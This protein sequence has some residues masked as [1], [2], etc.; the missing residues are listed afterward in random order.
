MRVTEELGFDH[1]NLLIF[2]FFVCKNTLD[3]NSFAIVRMKFFCEPDTHACSTWGMSTGSTSASRLILR[4]LKSFEP[5]AS[6]IWWINGKRS[7]PI[8]QVNRSIAQ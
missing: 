2:S 6:I 7:L 3:S 4:R 5:K 1:L 8:E